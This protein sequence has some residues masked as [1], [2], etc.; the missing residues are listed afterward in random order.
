MLAPLVRGGKFDVVVD[1]LCYEP[2]TAAASV[3]ACDGKVGQYVFLSS[4]SVYQ[5][6]APE[7][8]HQRS[9]AAGQP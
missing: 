1:F 6:P 2:S 3:A 8:P 7:S 4:A 5:K 9:H